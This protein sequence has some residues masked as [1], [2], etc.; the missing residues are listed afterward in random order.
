MRF[1]WIFPAMAALAS[2]STLAQDGQPESAASLNWLSGQW[3]NATGDSWIEEAWSMARGGILL[4]TNR[5]GQGRQT[6]AYEFI[7]IGPDEAGVLHYYAAPGG[8]APTPFRLVSQ[9]AQSAVFENPDHDYPTRIRYW[10][11]GDRLYAE[12]SGP[13]GA[14][15]NS[16]SF[17][18]MH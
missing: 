9:G 8:A 4:A 15:A 7:R 11:E 3:A 13:D 14:D 12:I 17:D 6:T 10:R 1:G 5:S 18:L 16:W 2:C